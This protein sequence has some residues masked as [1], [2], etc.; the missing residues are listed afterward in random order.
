LGFTAESLLFPGMS[1]ELSINS[2]SG[3]V[4]ELFP[5]GRDDSLPVADLSALSALLALLA[6]LVLLVLPSLA[7]VD[8]P[9]LAV[10]L[11]EMMST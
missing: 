1:F 11:L 9:M 2:N 4:V 6:P 3:S 8:S 5:V 7:V 10:P